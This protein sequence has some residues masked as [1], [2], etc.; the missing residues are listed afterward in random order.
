MMDERTSLPYEDIPLE[1]RAC[2]FHLTKSIPLAELLRK[3]NLD[4][5][6]QII[7]QQVRGTRNITPLTLIKLCK[8]YDDWAPVELLFA[9]L[10]LSIAIDDARANSGNIM[11][12]TIQATARIGELNQSLLDALKDGQVSTSERAAISQAAHQAIAELNDVVAVCAKGA[13]A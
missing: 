11:I 12:E 8:A 2:L 13:A 1:S 7:Y 5:H 6:L 10:G 9:D 4:G 3:V